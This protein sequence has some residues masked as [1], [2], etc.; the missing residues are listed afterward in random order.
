MDKK[1]AAI[2]GTAM[3]DFHL[4]SRNDFNARHMADLNF[5]GFSVVKRALAPDKC[6]AVSKL[7]D[8]DHYFRSTIDMS[9]YGFGRGVYRY[10]QSPLP[11]GLTE[12][13]SEL[14]DLLQPLANEWQDAL[15]LPH[16]PPGHPA[17]LARCHQAGQARPTPLLLKYQA[18]DFNCLHQD[19]YGDLVFPLQMAILLDRPGID[20]SGG[21]FVLT[22]QRPRR[23]SRASVVPLDQGDGVIFAVHSRP[24][25]GIKGSYRVSMR[26]G[27]ST[28]H[29][30][31]RR[32][33]GVILHDAH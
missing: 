19:L 16:F 20:F 11:Q 13:R 14:Y 28:I 10:F 8:Q 25:L 21:E 27:V 2:T 5:L 31:L 32:T 24:V 33:F 12:L 1:T 17:F 26:H 7:F 18:G 6:H 3:F 23:Q 30:G 9:R 29:H 22:E 4:P 15:G